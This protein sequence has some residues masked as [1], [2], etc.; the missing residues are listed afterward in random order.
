ME[1]YCLQNTNA[2]ESSFWHS[3]A[4]SDLTLFVSDRTFQVHR[5]VLC[6]RSQVFCDLIVT[7]TQVN[8]LGTHTLYNMQ[9]LTGTIIGTPYHWTVRA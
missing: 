1:L 5:L 7:D 9:K 3:G 6:V 8:R 2:N 4:F